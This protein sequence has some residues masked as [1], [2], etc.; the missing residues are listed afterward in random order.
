MCVH[1]TKNNS[2][3]PEESVRPALEHSKMPASAIPQSSWLLP[4]RS[5][6]LPSGTPGRAHLMRGSIRSESL[7]YNNKNMFFIKH[8]TELGTASQEA[9]VSVKEVP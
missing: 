4:H 2:L 5:H 6:T 8:K 3:P 1:E 7:G 9:G